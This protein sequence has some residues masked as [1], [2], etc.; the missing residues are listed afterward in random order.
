MSGGQFSSL[1][2]APDRKTQLIQVRQRWRP[3]THLRVSKI[4]GLKAKVHLFGLRAL[5]YGGGALAPSQ[6]VKVAA[7]ARVGERHRHL[8]RLRQNLRLQCGN[9]R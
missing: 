5:V 9:F 7:S 2:N 3:E 6:G 8:H 1:Q 4:I